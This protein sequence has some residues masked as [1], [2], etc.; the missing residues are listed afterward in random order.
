MNGRIGE[1]RMLHITNGDAVAAGIR[2]I[3][4]G[5]E[6]LPWRDVLHEGPVP[7]DLTYNELRDVRSRYLAGQ[8]WTNLERAR[9]DL[10]GRDET[11]AQLPLGAFVVLW[12]EHDLYDQLQLLQILDYFATHGPRKLHLELICVGEFAGVVPFHGLGQL[13]PAQLATLWPLRTLVSTPLLEAACQAWAAFR[14]PTPRPL[15]SFLEHCGR[16][17]PFLPAALRRHLQELP[18]VEEG[19]S[20]SEKQIL[21]SLEA[22]CQ[23]DGALFRACQA[24]EESPYLGDTPFFSYLKRLAGGPSPLLSLGE[25]VPGNR[26]V[27][28]TAAGADVLAG[29]RDQVRLNGIDRWWGGLRLVGHEVRWR[30]HEASKTVKESG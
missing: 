9:E 3:G 8:G 19:L 18:S 1:Q 30:W 13:S 17:L 14:A 7:A 2:G 29:R 28:R 6:V 26:S 21:R 5:G 23:T 11:L 25:G 16:Q 4:L 27:E 12:F 20:R 15:V 10:Q 24:L 22:G